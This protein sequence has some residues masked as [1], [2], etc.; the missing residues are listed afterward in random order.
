MGDLVV[1]LLLGLGIG[2]IAGWRGGLRQ[3][4]RYVGRQLRVDIDAK[5]IT[6]EEAERIAHLPSARK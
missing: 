6:R 5:L 2:F 4:G 3:A 1:G